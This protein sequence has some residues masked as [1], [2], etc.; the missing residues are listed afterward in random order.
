[1]RKLLITLVLTMNAMT[2]TSGPTSISESPEAG[3]A[4]YSGMNDLLFPAAPVEMTPYFESY[5]FEPIVY[6]DEKT[7]TFELFSSVFVDPNLPTKHADLSKAVKDWYVHQQEFYNVKFKLI[8]QS[9]V[10]VANAPA[11]YLL[12]ESKG[13]G[14][15]LEKTDTYRHHVYLF[16]TDTN[17]IAEVRLSRFKEN[18]KT[19]SGLW[20]QWPDFINSIKN[21][22]PD[23]AGLTTTGQDDNTRR[24]YAHNLSFD[25]PI[26]EPGGLYKWIIKNSAARKDIWVT[27]NGDITLNISLIDDYDFPVEKENADYIQ[28]ADAM[29]SGGADY[30]KKLSD[31]DLNYEKIEITFA[32]NKTFYGYIQKSE[33]HSELT[34]KAAYKT[35]RAIEMEFEAE[36]EVFDE[37][38]DEIIEWVKNI[39][40]LP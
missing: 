15:D 6:T 14:Q 39:I 30:F 35:G 33:T 12:I 13:Y 21:A 37:Y 18:D 17:S 5:R 25:I 4:P 20:R 32:K 8:K 23:S 16:L 9:D 28:E 34:L 36:N 19:D 2:V 38:K 10:K 22:E 40:V 31:L 27:K 29:E 26:G 11:K 1:M 7:K 24:Y 3:R